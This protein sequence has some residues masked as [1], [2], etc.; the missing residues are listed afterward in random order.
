[1]QRLHAAGQNQLFAIQSESEQQAV[2]V[3]GELDLATIELERAQVGVGGRQ[4]ECQWRGHRR[5]LACA[6]NNALT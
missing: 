4:R 1:M 6:S 2:G 5:A 3:Q